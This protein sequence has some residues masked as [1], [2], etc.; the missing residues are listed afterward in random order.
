MWDDSSIEH[1][2]VGGNLDEFSGYLN[3]YVNFDIL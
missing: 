2:P 3:L 1:C